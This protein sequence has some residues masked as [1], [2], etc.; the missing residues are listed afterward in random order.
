MSSSRSKLKK[1]E[2][3]EKTKKTEKTIFLGNYI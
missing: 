3:I 1:T 2:K